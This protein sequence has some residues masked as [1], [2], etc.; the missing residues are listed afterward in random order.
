MNS[1]FFELLDAADTI[2]VCY[3]QCLTLL[4]TNRVNLREIW[5]YI[6]IERNTGY[7]RVGGVG[8]STFWSFYSLIDP[9][10]FRRSLFDI[11]FFLRPHRQCSFAVFP[12]LFKM[13]GSLA[14]LQNFTLR[15][16]E[17]RFVLCSLYA[18]ASPVLNATCFL[19][20]RVAPHAVT[21]FVLTKCFKWD[22]QVSI[23]C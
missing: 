3:C 21:R 16:W 12:R 11:D 20:T 6:L 19:E 2:S 8:V 4:L 18:A 5:E 7:L 13:R 9:S 23:R 10:L 17:L 1:P 14:F 22:A 15:V